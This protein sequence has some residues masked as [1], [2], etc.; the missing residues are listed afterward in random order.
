MAWAYQTAISSGFQNDMSTFCRLYCESPNVGA[1]TIDVLSET[2]LST[3]NG[4]SISASFTGNALVDGV[5]GANLTQSFSVGANSLTYYTGYARTVGYNANGE[6]TVQWGGYL[7]TN[8]VLAFEQSAYAWFALPSIA[9]LALTSL[10]VTRVSDSQQTLS[11]SIPSGVTNTSVIIQRRTDDGSWLTIAQPAGN[12]SSYAD[13][14][15]VANRKY[16]YRVAGVRNG[17][18]AAWTGTVTVYTTPAAPSVVSAVKVGSN[19]EVDASGLPAWATA[20]DIEDNGS[21]VDTDVTAFPWVHVA[22]NPAVTH[23]YKVRSKRGALVSAWSAPSNTVQLLAAPNAP[24][25][26]SPN[27]GM[28][29]S[30]GLVRLAWVHNQVDT[31]AQ[32]TAEVRYREVGGA[33][34][35][36][37]VGT[38]SFF[39]ATLAEGDWEWQART[40]GDHPDWSPWSAIASVT[41]ITRPGVAIVQP[42]DGWGQPVLPVEWT[43]TQAQALP[44]SAWEVQLLDQLS[45]VLETLTG[46]GAATSA[47]LATR[48][49]DGGSYTVRARAATGGIWSQWIAQAFDVAFVPPA[50]PT[51]SGGWDEATGSVSLTVADGRGPVIADVVNYAPSLLG[52]TTAVEVRR[53]YWTRTRFSITGATGLSMESGV[54]GVADSDGLKVAG[55]RA[56][57]SW[58]FSHGTAFASNAGDVWALAFRVRNNAAVAISIAAM[59]S[60][61]GASSETVGG[62]VSIGSGETKDVR[63]TGVA[64]SGLTSM[65]A[66]LRAVGA[67]SSADFTVLDV[68][69][70]EKGTSAFGAPFDGGMTS[71]DHDL[72]PAWTGTANASASILT[73]QHLTALTDNKCISI[74]TAAGDEIRQIP[75][76]SS[77]AYS[78]FSV[79]AAARAAGTFIGTLRLTDTILSPLSGNPLRLRT[80]SPDTNSGTTPN[81]PGIYPLR[82]QFA[83]S[84][85]W[86]A[87][88]YHGGA[89]GSGDAYWSNI[90]LFAGDY[91]GPWFD[92]D[93]GQITVGDSVMVTEWDG[94]PYESVSRAVMA[95]ETMS[96]LVERSIDGG[97]TWEPALATDPGVTVSDWESLSRG[98]TLYRVTGV[99]ASGAS[100]AVEYPVTADSGVLWLSGGVGFSLTAPLPLDPKIAFDDRRDR[101][102]EYYEGR[103]MPVAYAGEHLKTV[104][105][106]SGSLIDREDHSAEVDQLRALIRDP[107]PTHLLRDPDGRRI[108][109]VVS[110]VQ[111]P[112]Q[113]AIDRADGW[114][115][116]WQYSFSIEETD[117]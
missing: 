82:H 102:T 80:I 68:P 2:Y 71:P 21:T 65:T 70:L 63:V 67:L 14:T 12:V 31:T 115:G 16:E 4:R 34:T 89:R 59:L 73:G 79:A 6:A 5:A 56:A 11:W 107:E 32:T 101:S 35:T 69:M 81:L 62:A 47:T 43:F 105:A 50:A 44:Q 13:T 7:R 86:R 33:W 97:T 3:T 55:S 20:Y 10:G 42:G 25:G 77:N 18:Q 40:K 114:A 92:G 27:G 99:S 24:S 38:D 112:R 9:P 108:Y 23:T 111:I 26:L 113:Q 88:L 74:V 54:S 17:R 51:V 90:G 106:V 28:A 96:I 110:S 45:V 117:Q 36:E 95:P 15:T 60:W 19:I 30:D 76:G 75:T 64:P 87:R 37:T 91:Q 52:P 41:V 29:P 53:N 94:D 46:S 8:N 66:A 116:V 58:V 109:G 39:D 57:N 49:V 103:E 61:N 93:T 78:E 83:L 48:L 72:T 98:V 1:R 84:S 22:P 85:F 100:T 104:V